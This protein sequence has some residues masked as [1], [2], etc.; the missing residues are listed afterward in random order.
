MDSLRRNGAL[1]MAF[2]L[3]MLWVAPPARGGEFTGSWEGI[4]GRSIPMTLAVNNA[5]VI[6][7]FTYRFTSSIGPRCVWTVEAETAIPVSPAGGFSAVDVGG[8]GVITSDSPGDGSLGTNLDIE[9]HFSSSSLEGAFENE[10]FAHV[11]NGVPVFG[12]FTGSVEFVL[13][14]KTPPP[15]PGVTSS[16]YPD[17]RFW[18]EIS[19][20]RIGTAVADCLPETVCIAGAIPTRAE[21]FVRIVG[22]KPNG[23]LW[24]NIVKF[25]TTKTEVWIEQISTGVTKYYLLPPL[26]TDSGELPG[27]VDKDGFVP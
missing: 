5:D 26:P 17:F 11:C 12:F 15:V 20:T 18:V 19:D 24:P 16:Q 3:L 1:S 25:N 21:V 6:T 10:S 8:S 7:G 27:V 22:P 13:E 9:G 4:L 2:V 23:R 14:R